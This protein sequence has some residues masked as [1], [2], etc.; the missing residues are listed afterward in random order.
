MDARLRNMSGKKAIFVVLDSDNED[1]AK[2]KKD[3]VQMYKSLMIGTFKCDCADKIG[4]WLEIRKNT[5][6]RFNYF[7]GKL[8]SFCNENV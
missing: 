8:D 1:C 6:P 3:L 5:S 7:I 2:L 4:E